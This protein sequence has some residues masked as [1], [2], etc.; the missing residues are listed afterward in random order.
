MNIQNAFNTSLQGLQRAQHEVSQ[1]SAD[2]ARPTQEVQ[3]EVADTKLAPKNDIATNLTDL[4][5]SKNLASANLKSFETA[6]EMLGNLIDTK[7]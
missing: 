7:A 5:N 3:A 4:L 1:T 6:N 2:I